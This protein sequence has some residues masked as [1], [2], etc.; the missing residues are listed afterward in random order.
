MVGL[1]LWVNQNVWYS[2]MGGN[3][4]SY[5]GAFVSINTLLKFNMETENDGFQKESPFPEA[6]FQVPC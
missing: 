5:P 3:F 2:M 4:F 1:L 6:D